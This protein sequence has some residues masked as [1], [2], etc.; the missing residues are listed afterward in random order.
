MAK[1]INN[2][3]YAGQIKHSTELNIGEL[4]IWPGFDID[5]NVNSNVIMQLKYLNVSTENTKCCAR[6]KINSAICH[7]NFC[8]GYRC[9]C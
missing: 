4:V 5:S 3:Y 7:P 8:C 1:L 2:T 6:N 9:C